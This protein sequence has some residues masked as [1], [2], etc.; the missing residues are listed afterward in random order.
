MNHGDSSMVITKH[1]LLMNNCSGERK[2]YEMRQMYYCYVIG[3][4]EFQQY[5][6]IDIKAAM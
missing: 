3:Q 5:Y 4:V 6:A 1:L 2:L